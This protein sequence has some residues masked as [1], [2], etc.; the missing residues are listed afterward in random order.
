MVMQ[1]IALPFILLLTLPFLSEANLPP[2]HPPPLKK[3]DTIAIIAP[4][5]CP[6]E[7]SKTVTR[8]VNMLTQRGYRVKVAPNLLTRNGYLAGTDYDRARALMEAWLDPDV[9]ALWCY[10]GGFGCTRILDRLDYAAIQRHPKILIGMS[11][12]TA[13]HAAI[14]QRTGLVTYLGPN[15]NAVYGRDEK[16]DSLFNERELWKMISPSQ[17][18]APAGYLYQIPKSFPYSE[19]SVT[20]IRPGIARGTLTGGTLSL[21][22]SMVGTPWEIDTRG[23]ILVL[24]EIGEEPYRIDRWLRQLKQS[25]S[26][27]QPAGVILCSWKGCHG[28]KTKKT[29]SLENIFKDYFSSSSY[30]VLYGFP[31]G[32]IPDQV[33]LPLNVLAELDS[34]KK[35]LR[36]LGDTVGS[37]Q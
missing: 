14:N 1:L 20:T 12:V 4:A 37:R 10:R 34:T 7:D 18:T 36:L 21:V 27:E 6:D 15:L 26:L 33:T 5:S 17:R 32:H 22:A 3:G 24:E 30:P 28:S 11:D 8:A 31:S 9:K 2:I 23:K 16:G 25:G 19:L 35:T 29:I 13:L